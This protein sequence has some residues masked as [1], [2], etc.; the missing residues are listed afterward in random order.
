MPP[1]QRSYSW[2]EKEALELLSDLKDASESDE[3]HFI[4]AIVVVKDEETDSFEIVDG[5]Q[6]LTTLTI[7]LAV[8]R[9][10]EKDPEVAATIHSLIG[11][12]GRPMLSEDARW[13]LTL[14]HIDGPFFRAVIQ[15]PGS[16]ARAA[17]EAGESES[18]LRMTRNASAFRKALNNLSV[19]ERNA[20]TD[21]IIN[22]C[23]IVR[24]TVA[25]RDAGYKV[26]R[27]L[28]DRGK[29]PN[30]HD[31]IKT[32]IFE[33]AGFSVAEA[34]AQSRRWA[35]HEALLGGN[36]FDDLLRQIRFTFDKSNK[37]DLVNGFRKPPLGRMPPLEF[38]NHTLPRYVRAYDKVEHT[39]LEGSPDSEKIRD[40]LNQ[41][42]YLDH[43][44]WKAPAV[45]YIATR[46][47]ASA[48]ALDFFK[49]LERL[50]YLLQLVVPNRDH[51][52]KRYRKVIETIDAK[53]RDNFYGRG[54]SLAVTKEDGKRVHDRLKGRFATF[55]QRRAMVLR[56]NAALEDGR[57]VPPGAD[58]TVEHVL[59]RNPGKNSHW[60][61]VW[62]DEKARRE[63]CDTIGNLVLLPR[64]INE[65][66][67]TLTYQEKKKLYFTSDERALFA[68][69]QAIEDE[70]TWTP[71]VVSRRS[72][73]L[74]DIL[75]RDWGYDV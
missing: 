31:I 1:Y 35:E 65:Q 64:S 8:L 40:R 10:L 54:G 51:R 16:T 45:H 7:L 66:A 62:P 71:E 24:V 57:T 18:Q 19:E 12:T 30:A 74:A 70:H 43:Q 26:F 6:R 21:T 53:G 68:L 72:A 23:A 3:I 36:A 60:L 44:T 25:D 63:L 14:N 2:G 4:G 50:G 22:G 41:L 56:L 73:F 59:P 48:D 32:E 38:L 55:T 42:H 46:G 11:D 58:A 29:E 69:T 15:Q 49:G 47:E 28:N 5:Q 37:G 67:D 75:C 33:R 52:N 34:D 13:R 9:D 20:L 61:V 39:A 27:V 17:D